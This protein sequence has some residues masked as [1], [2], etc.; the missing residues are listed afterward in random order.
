MPANPQE[1]GSTAIWIKIQQHLNTVPT[2][3]IGGMK[4]QGI[5]CGDGMVTALVPREVALTAG[6]YPVIIECEGLA[7][8]LIG[9]LEI[10]V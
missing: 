4:A 8:T 5:V 2:I 7:P 1:G 10:Y 9:E 6:S 3:I